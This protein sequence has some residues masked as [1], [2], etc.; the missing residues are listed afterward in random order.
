MS[1]NKGR[2]LNARLFIEGR[3][4]PFE[5]C[6]TQHMVGQPGTATIQVPPLPEIKRIKPRTMVQ[7]FIKD[8]TAPKGTKPW[9]LLFEGEVYGYSQGKSTN[10][11]SF[12]IYA[13]DYTNYW[14][15][16][17]QFYINLQTSMDG[18]NAVFESSQAQAAAARAGAG[19]TFIQSSIR[20]YLT[21]IINNK[22]KESSTEADFLAAITEVLKKIEE[23]NP[24]FR[25]NQLRYRI[26][27]RILLGSSKSIGKLFNFTDK[28]NL[29]DSL[30]GGGNGG[31]Q[32]VRMIVNKLMS[33]IF[34]D[35]VSIPAP[36][37]VSKTG[38]T[39][40]IGP[41]SD[42]V[43]GSFIFK[44]DTFMLPPPK[45]NVIYPDLYSSLSFSR[46]FFNE[47]TRFKT[48][49]VDTTIQSLGGVGVPGGRPFYSPNGFSKFRTGQ[50]LQLTSEAQFDEEVDQG[51]YGD[52]VNDSE[53]TTTKQDFNYLSREELLKGIFPDLSGRIPA[54]QILMQLVPKQ[55]D[56]DDPN[57]IS[58]DEFFQQATNYL[59][60]KKR[61]ASRTVSASGPLNIAPV[62]GFPVLFIDDS[63]AEQNVIGTLQSISHNINTQGGATTSY[64]VSFA[65]D[66]DEE[67]LWNNDVSEPPIPP[68]FDPD[69]F[70]QV[71]PVKVIDYQNLPQSDKEKVQRFE[72]ITGFENANIKAYY[73]GLFGSTVRNAALGAEPIVSARF[74]NV[75]SATLAILNSYRT[76]KRKGEEKEFIRIQTRRDYVLMDEN[77]RFLGAEIKESQKRINF[78][79]KQDII[80][81]GRIFDGGFVDL[82]E[83]TTA[84][85]KK[86]QSL[87]GTEVTK[88][89]RDP[90]DVYRRRLFRERGF[91]G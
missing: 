4:V 15:N 70:G 69:T 5:G 62:P 75:Y 9:V 50:D 13:M 88:K 52:E 71:R 60:Y 61:L 48:N 42:K 44:P 65:R 17:K 39:D 34:H 11:R 6:S 36:S 78:L 64:S 82:A 23:V 45:C 58:Q 76:A 21:R 33:I 46:N 54:A 68:W 77:F 16:A 26:N 90:I 20:S 22:L 47:V 55:P 14:D 73:G 43:I 38:V 19:T 30:V 89:R 24:F 29:M 10:G 7:V 79:N 35:F 84:A 72:T 27:D 59:F 56:P 32:T 3:S 80:F 86:L 51:K 31:M 49:P 40:G 85:D 57:Q 12:N 2:E 8:F 1:E 74:P 91:R 83:N 63:I 18:P 67:D 81:S 28:Q 53:L 41:K 66:V 25:F 87:F 37:K